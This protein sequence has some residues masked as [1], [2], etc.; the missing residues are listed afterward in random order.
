M[1]DNLGWSNESCRESIRAFDRVFMEVPAC[2]PWLT[3]NGPGEF[4][5][6]RAVL[7][8]GFGVFLEEVADV[9]REA[10]ELFVEGLS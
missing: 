2:R 3:R 8:T 6:L 10:F 4:K 7:H 5:R 9:D 1:V